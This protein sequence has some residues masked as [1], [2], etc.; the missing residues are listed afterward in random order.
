MFYIGICDDELMY[1]RHISKLCE[2][3]FQEMG[4]KYECIEFASG[5]E[6]MSHVG[7]QMQL[8]FL[9]I[10]MKDVDGIEVMHWVELTDAVWR[11]VF[12]SGHE[13]LV[14]DTFSIK[15]LGFVRK[16]AN[17]AD[18][19]R[20]I[21]VALK[22]KKRN[23][24]YEF[25]IEQKKCYKSSEEIYCLEAEGNYTY[26]YEKESKKLINDN[27]K[28][29]QKKM[30]ETSIIRIHKSYMI[31]LIYVQCWEYDKVVLKNGMELSIGR[32]YRKVAR[33]AY[34]AHIRKVAMER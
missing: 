2:E 16:P 9:D 26:L 8:L 3:I 20:W 18:I 33:E 7:P 1:R 17:Y 25:V 13:Q 21:Q 10:E 34:Y 14:W 32:Q 23:A 4:Q 27:L 15:T 5:E 6:V 30:Q 11:V 22:E 28:V 24:I 12:V 19:K 31:N 29:W